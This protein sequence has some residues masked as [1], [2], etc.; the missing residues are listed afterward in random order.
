V[1]HPSL[2]DAESSL[3]RLK[4]DAGSDLGSKHHL[5]AFHVVVHDILESWLTSILIYEIK[6]NFLVCSYLNPFIS[7]DKVYF[8][9]HVR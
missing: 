1:E 8:A 3:A 5:R 4:D 6:V 9:P 7:L 2:V